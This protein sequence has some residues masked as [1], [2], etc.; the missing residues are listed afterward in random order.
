M[1]K[2]TE[3]CI[4]FMKV[5]FGLDISMYETSFLEMTIK[6]R[7]SALSIKT[8]EDYLLFLDIVPGESSEIIALL[9]NS[10]SEF[11][12]NPL[13]FTYL[14]Q[15]ILPSLILQKI[16]NK[17]KEIRVWSAACASGQEAYSLAI[18]FDEMVDRVKSPVSCHIFATD[19]NQAEVDNAQRGIYQTATVDKV[20]LKRI[21][22]YFSQQDET[23]TVA[24]QLRE[25]INFS[26][27]DLLAEQY[28]CPPDSIYGNFDL[29]FCSNLLFYYKPEYR[30]RIIDKAG[31]C[32]ASGGY[33]I[34]G[35]TER[36]IVKENNYRE[37]FLHSGIF[38]QRMKQF[39]DPSENQKANTGNL[40]TGHLKH[41]T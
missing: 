8:P 32:L 33:L 37:V 10:Y 5:S 12:R 24:R 36:E 31:N 11:F 19:I 29:V 16:N 25:Y 3:K 21:K 15:V 9:S 22:T 13:T 40:T 14:E 39:S 6:T 34:T 17:E 28:I 38:Q 26:V 2:E 23:F 27:F 20:S 7:M 35:E 4:H 18:L 41:E 30:Q 1:S